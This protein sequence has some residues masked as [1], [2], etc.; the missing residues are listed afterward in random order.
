MLVS[1]PAYLLRTGMNAPSGCTVLAWFSGPA[2]FVPAA[3]LEDSAHDGL[4]AVDVLSSSPGIV[5]ETAF[6]QWIRLPAGEPLPDGDGDVLDAGLG[7]WQ[8]RDQSGG[9]VAIAADR[10]IRIERN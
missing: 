7:W 1:V 10:L 8:R 6:S 4:D 9:G 5:L 2:E 3:A